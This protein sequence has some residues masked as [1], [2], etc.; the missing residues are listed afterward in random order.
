MKKLLV[1]LIWGA[2]VV[3]I[4]QPVVGFLLEYGIT[5]GVFAAKDK[6]DL[7]VGAKFIAYA[8]GA[9]VFYLKVRKES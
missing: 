9:L 7:A 4:C 2:I 8:L 6:A 3:F 1:A 5:A